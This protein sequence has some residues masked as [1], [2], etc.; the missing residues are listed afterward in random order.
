MA[1]SST[2]LRGRNPKMWARLGILMSVALRNL[3][4]TWLNLIIGL[5]ILAGTVLVVVGGALLDSLD[6][7]MSSSII[8]SVAGD[9]QVY[10]GDS[11]DDLEVFGSFG[12]DD[13][14]LT[15]ILDFSKLDA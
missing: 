8:G 15:P 5:L 10:S 3:F 4:A 2:R 9:A 1:G 13:S 11:K 12:G 7:S 6:A 14:D